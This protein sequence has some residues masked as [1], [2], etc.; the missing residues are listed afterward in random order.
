MGD[1]PKCRKINL[2]E[3]INRGKKSLKA[4]A[5]GLGLATITM[6]ST[7]SQ[8]SNAVLPPVEQTNIQQSNQ[9]PFIM[10]P[11]NQKTAGSQFAWHES[12]YSHSSHASHES[13][14]SHYSSRW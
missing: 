1:F 9:T 14:Y 2:E 10:H 5:S 6:L 11:A 3:I 7:G 4:L 13:H 8:G 12:H